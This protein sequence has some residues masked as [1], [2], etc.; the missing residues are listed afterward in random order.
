[1]RYSGYKIKKAEQRL[2]EDDE[3]FDYDSRL[4]L[5]T[6]TMLKYSK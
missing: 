2:Y 1:M 6:N 3:E 5:T 4:N